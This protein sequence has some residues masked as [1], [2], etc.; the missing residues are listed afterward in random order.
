MAKI[1]GWKKTLEGK[2]ETWY[3]YK[4]RSSY[5]G[6]LRLVI[7]TRVVTK[8]KY[9]VQILKDG[10]YAGYGKFFD[11]KKETLAYVTK[12][13]RTHPGDSELA[14]KYV[15]KDGFDSPFEVTR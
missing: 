4:S 8:P 5:Y 6:N 1:K 10:W 14:E 9:N 12:Y 13:M 15:D 11:T 2:N 3:E 7:Q